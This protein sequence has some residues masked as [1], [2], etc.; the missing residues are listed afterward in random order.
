MGY[1]RL[2]ENTQ[3][4]PLES[5]QNL[6]LKSYDDYREGMYAAPPGQP[7]AGGPELYRYNGQLP[8]AKVWA[9]NKLRS[10]ILA[11]D[12]VF[13]ATPI[14]FIGTCYSLTRK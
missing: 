3:S 7:P 4:F 5:R 11:F 13:H 12:I 14:M 10:F 2:E 1:T 8:A 9:M 6:N